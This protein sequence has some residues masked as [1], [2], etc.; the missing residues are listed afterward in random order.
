MSG[1]EFTNILFK[2]H[3][4]FYKKIVTKISNYIDFHQEV[5][6][7]FKQQQITQ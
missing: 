3:C 4:H 2:W 5:G 1:V 7:F 6:G